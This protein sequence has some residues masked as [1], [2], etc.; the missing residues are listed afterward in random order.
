MSE[1]TKNELRCFCLR[2]PLLAFYGHGENGE[3]YVHQKVHKQGRVFGESIFRSGT[4]EIKC[5]EC[6]R[7]TKIRLSQGGEFISP[8]TEKE[9]SVLSEGSAIQ[10][11]YPHSER[12]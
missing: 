7:W 1:K 3:P 11:L 2:R 12:K 4:V 6:Y 10:C 8:P 9:P 5:R